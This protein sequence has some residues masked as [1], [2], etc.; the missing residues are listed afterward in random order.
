MWPEDSAKSH[1]P[2]AT[3]HR[4]LHQTGPRETKA[5][6]PITWF[7]YNSL[8]YCWLRVALILT[9]KFSL[10]HRQG[11]RDCN[12]WSFSVLKSGSSLCFAINLSKTVAFKHHLW[13]YTSFA[14]Q[15]YHLPYGLRV[16]FLQT[17]VATVA[18]LSLN[19]WRR[20]CWESQAMAT[21]AVTVA[22]SLLI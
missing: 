12:G 9:K 21:L 5:R 19:G 3:K 18:V 13:Y 22:F 7:L 17:A 10:V 14:V 20:W 8:C 4:V 11:G 15:V 2:T 6:C 16:N 1:K